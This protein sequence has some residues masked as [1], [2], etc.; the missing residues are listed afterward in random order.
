MIGD[1]GFKSGLRGTLETLFVTTTTHPGKARRTSRPALPPT[2]TV[3]G[4]SLHPTL[5]VG[6]GRLIALVSPASV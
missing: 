5:W 3:S 4:L 6:Q 2:K 1:V